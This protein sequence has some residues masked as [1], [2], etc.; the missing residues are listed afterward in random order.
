MSC[1]SSGPGWPCSH[2]EARL[3]RSSVPS[4]DSKAVVTAAEVTAAVVTAAVVTAAVVTAAVVAAAVVTAAVVT[5][6]ITTAVTAGGRRRRLV[7][8]ATADAST[9]AVWCICIYIL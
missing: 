5:A 4:A 9:G 2:T 1:L 7:L 8:R 3:A 6:A